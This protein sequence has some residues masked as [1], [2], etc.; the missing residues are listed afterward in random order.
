MIKSCGEDILEEKR[1]TKCVMLRKHWMDW[2]SRGA[3]FYEGWWRE[4]LKVVYGEVMEGLQHYL[5]ES[6]FD[7]WLIFL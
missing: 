5:R 7:F 6:G 3:G 4:A 2:F 1:V